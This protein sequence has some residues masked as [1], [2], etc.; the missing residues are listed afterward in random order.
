[1]EERNWED[2]DADCLANVLGRVGLDSLLFDIPF[3]CKSWYKFT[4]NP[5]CWDTI[6]FPSNYND[7][8]VQKRFM[9]EYRV[10]K[11]SLDAFVK[12]IVDRS[13]G[14]CTALYLHHLYFVK[15]ETINYVVDKCPSLRRLSL[16]RC[17]SG[18]GG[19][20]AE[21]IRKLKHLEE[22]TLRDSANLI[23]ITREININCTNFTL[24]AISH[25]GACIKEEEA[26]AIVNNLPKIKYLK[27]SK[28]F[29]EQKSL[30]M[31]LK[32]C[33]NLVHLDVSNCLGFNPDDKILALASHIGEFNYK[34]SV[35]DA[36]LSADYWAFSN[37]WKDGV[38]QRQRQRERQVTPFIHSSRRRNSSSN[39]LD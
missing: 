20:N 6:V 9:K 32:G 33:K 34:G 17:Q 29:I 1:M 10:K 39:L 23:D 24:L 26:S 3:V 15:E 25:G 2:L 11:F 30:V 38:R 21:L 8:D 14:K 4:L 37:E 5:F 18:D 27:L 28:G 31:I 13:L 16:P 22:L 12:F 36:N 7:G 19:F 35:S